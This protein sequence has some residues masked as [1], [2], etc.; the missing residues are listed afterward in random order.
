M[1][2][3]EA[4]TLFD[5]SPLIAA[6]KIFRFLQFLGEMALS[7]LDLAILYKKVPFPLN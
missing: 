5:I 7:F 2:L 1:L 4:L 3:D 6:P